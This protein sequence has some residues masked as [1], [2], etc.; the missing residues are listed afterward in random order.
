MTKHS[1]LLSEIERETASQLLWAKINNITDITSTIATIVSSAV[2]TI[3]ISQHV[4]ASIYFAAIP[5]LLTSIQKVVNMRGKAIQYYVTARQY[6][7]IARKIEYGG[8]TETDAVSE[9]NR[10]DVDLEKT[11]L[12]AAKV[13]EE[14]PKGE[15]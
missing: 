3:L 15:K 2:A 8:L 7:S 6:N 13:K 5:G 12:E 11:W 1:K 10:V 14:P 9:L 4:G